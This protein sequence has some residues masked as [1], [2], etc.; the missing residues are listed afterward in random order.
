MEW[1]IRQNGLAHSPKWIST[2]MIHYT[3]VYI[4]MGW[5]LLGVDLRASHPPGVPAITPGPEAQKPPARSNIYTCI[6]YHACAGPF[7][8]MRQSILANAPIHFIEC[9][10]LF[11]RMRLSILSNAPIYFIECAC[12]FRRMHNGEITIGRLWHK[13]Y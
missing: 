1:R 9:A 10:Y 3:C 13:F 5:G 2:C 11:Y 8:R 4:R 7:W 12:L 6:V